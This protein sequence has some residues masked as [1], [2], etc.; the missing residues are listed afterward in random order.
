LQ[1]SEKCF[2]SGRGEDGA[3]L[4]EIKAM[5]LVTCSRSAPARRGSSIMA[6]GAAALF[7]MTAAGFSLAVD[8]KASHGISTVSEWRLRGTLG[9]SDLLGNPLP[10]RSEEPRVVKFASL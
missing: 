6:I 5:L 4:R 2:F 8:D 1:L 10:R 7:A 9:P 3:S